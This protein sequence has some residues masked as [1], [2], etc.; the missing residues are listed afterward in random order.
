[1]RPAQTRKPHVLVVNVF[2]APHTYGGATIVAEQ[3][4]QEL[5]RS[6]GFDVSAISAFSRAD[7]EPYAVLKVARG[8]IVNYLINL[9]PNRSFVETYDNGQVTEIVD[10]LLRTLGPDVV[11]L[12]CLQDIG[13]GII[14][15]AKRQN[16]P[17]VL[18]THD[19]WWLCERQF[20]IRMDGRYCG[21]NPVN[22][23]NCSGCADNLTKART[24]SEVLISIASQADIITY[25]SAFAQ[26]L[27][28]SSG[29][30]AH[31]KSLVWENGVQLPSDHF[32]EMQ[33]A[34]RE[35]SGRLSFGFVGGPSQIK[36]WPL[37][38]QAFNEI[39]QSHFEGHLVDGS[40][41]GSWWTDVDISKMNGDWQIHERFTQENMDEFY[42]K[43]DVLLF[44]SQWKETFGLTIR[45]AL[46]RG[47]RVIQT[48]SGGTTEHLA[49]DPAHMLQIGDGPDRLIEEL[50][51]VLHPGYQNPDKMHVTS[52]AEQ[53]TKMADCLRDLINT[54]QSTSA[55]A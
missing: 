37:I 27:N 54:P 32:F 13:A 38:H 29:L 55:T 25:P 28:E 16:V 19:F 10:G 21:Q 20:M 3:V 4:A 1:M 43:I 15:A 36:G 47:I 46:A 53:A 49:A 5:K 2:F 35:K 48:D 30:K 31:H 34:R 39:S 22:V 14:A 50:E 12:H 18:S 42:A 52:F 17:T 9:P 45:E 40:L 24:R 33:A 8:G 6:H 23:E 44:L 7:L 11:H 26:K 41:D 51:T